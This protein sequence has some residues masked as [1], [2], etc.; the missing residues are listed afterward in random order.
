MLQLNILLFIGRESRLMHKL[1]CYF[2]LMHIFNKDGN[3]SIIFELHFNGLNFRSVLRMHE[4]S[5]EVNSLRYI[6]CSCK[7][8]NSIFIKA[9][10]QLKSCLHFFQNTFECPCIEEIG[11][12]LELCLVERLHQNFQIYKNEVIQFSK[13]IYLIRFWKCAHSE[14][15]KLSKFLWGRRRRKEYESLL[16]VSLQPLGQTICLCKTFSA[17]A[18]SSHLPS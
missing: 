9:Y 1:M 5:L 7:H 18:C 4:F 17:P 8:L 15:Q 14:K 16:W 3:E 10:V 12:Y 11:K 2:L 6:H 13:F